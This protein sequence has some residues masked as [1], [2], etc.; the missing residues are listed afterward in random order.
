MGRA[1]LCGQA[2]DLLRVGAGAV[3]RC[4]LGRVRALE[5]G[6]LVLVGTPERGHFELVRTLQ[7]AQLLLERT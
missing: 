6:D 3:E 2:R 1:H 4:E 7:A 5:G